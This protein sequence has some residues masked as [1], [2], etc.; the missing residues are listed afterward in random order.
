MTQGDAAAPSAEPSVEFH[1]GE[2]CLAAVDRQALSTLM[3]A[4]LPH[5]PQ[6]VLRVDA[7]LVGDAAMSALHQRYSGVQGTTDVLS[8]PG[9]DGAAVDGRIEV[10]LIISVEVAMREAT[11]R[12]HAI[13]QEILLYA[14]HGTLH[15]CGL[16]DDTEASA[17]VIHAHEDRILC[18]GGFG[19]VYAAKVRQPPLGPMH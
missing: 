13:E 16:T 19:S 7:L 9:H 4:L 17:L 2:G 8:F 18:A 12:G 3:R 10:D 15:A 1:A 5:F 14:V 6:K 11:L